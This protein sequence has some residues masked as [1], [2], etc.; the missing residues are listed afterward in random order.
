[1]DADAVRRPADG[2]PER[3]TDPADPAFE[4]SGRQQYQLHSMQLGA[5]DVAL[6][7]VMDHLEAIGAWD[8]TTFVVVSDHGI[9]L[10]NPDFGRE[11]TRQQR[12]GAVPHRDVHQGGGP[13]GG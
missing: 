2:V 13:G 4:W 10:L 7:R 8:D 6:G 5:A 11:R 12:G 1:M 9:S 3:I